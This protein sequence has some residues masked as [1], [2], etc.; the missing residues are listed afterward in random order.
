MSVKIIAF[1]L[2]VLCCLLPSSLG[3]A[4]GPALQIMPASTEAPATDDS[5]NTF[6]SEKIAACAVRMSSGERK[7]LV[8][9][10]ITESE[11]HGYDPLFV[12]A[13]L[14]VESECDPDARGPKGSMGLIQLRP[15]TAR[16]VAAD[17]GLRWRGDSMLNDSAI[18]IQLALYYLSQLEERFSDPY[19]ALAAYNLGPTKV[20]QLPRARAR[21]STYVRKVL[22][23]YHNLLVTQASQFS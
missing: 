6:L 21:R 13:M 11:R 8:D 2:V 15:A 12:Q 19:L 14:E 7:R 23:R 10:I 1:A 20:A 5:V 22:G 3:F 17:V 9:A 4:A 16:A 18:N